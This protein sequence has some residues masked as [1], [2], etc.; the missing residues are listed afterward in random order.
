MLFEELLSA[1]SKELIAQPACICTH[2]VLVSIEGVSLTCNCNRL[3]RL[4]IATCVVIGPQG[5]P[6]GQMDKCKHAGSNVRDVILL[7]EI[8]YR[9]HASAGLSLYC[10]IEP[11]GTPKCH[12][13]AYKP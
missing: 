10:N 2:R 13:L 3:G 1:I 7:D 12:A 4:R 8:L 6:H 5:L 9:L 11:P